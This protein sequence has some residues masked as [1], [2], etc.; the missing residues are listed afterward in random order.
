MGQKSKACK[1]CLRRLDEGLGGS[2][3]HDGI[4]M[5]GN[6]WDLR[7]QCRIAVIY[8]VPKS[9]AHPGYWGGETL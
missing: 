6:E 9:P 8:F 7:C 1:K 3:V 4:V 5:F 2:L